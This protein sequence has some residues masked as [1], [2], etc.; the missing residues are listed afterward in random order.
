LAA[1]LREALEGI[2]F[3]FPAPASASAEAKRA[4]LATE[5]DQS[6]GPA[7]EAVGDPV[8]IAVAGPTGVGKSVLANT[9]IGGAYSA[10]SALRPTTGYPQLLAHPD[11][12]AL[13][14]DH[15]VRSVAKAHAVWDAPV[16]WAILDCGDPFAVGNDSLKAQP[17]VPM[18]AWLAV[19]SAL[20]YGDSLV[21][22]LLRSLAGR[23]EPIALVVNRVSE[24][25]GATIEA[26]VKER[27]ANAGLDQIA[28]FTVAEAAG[29]P[30]TLP[31]EHVADL[32]RWLEDQFPIPERLPD[33]PDLRVAVGRLAEQAA[34]LADAQA[35]HEASVDLLRSATEAHLAE[36]AQAAA[37][38]TPGPPDPGLAQAWLDQLGPHGALS[39]IDQE[40]T[41]EQRRRLAA[42][43]APLSR[44]VS[45]AV[46][47]GFRRIMTDARAALASVWQGA[48]VP[49]GTRA[50]LVRSGLDNAE[51]GADLGG[52]AGYGLWTQAVDARLRRSGD[53]AVRRAAEA[54]GRPGLVCLAQAAA[55]GLEGPAGF[56]AG[57]L[58]DEGKRLAE[59][60]LEDLREVRAGAVRLALAVFVDTVRDVER[61][62]SDT[63][64][65]AADRLAF[66][67]KQVD[68]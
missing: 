41:P 25:T 19:T 32:R 38:F 1:I 33:G 47:P 35:V 42:G 26:D 4:A 13:Q 57:W 53:Q 65:W 37:D 58:G 34:E 21:W 36:A 6:A 63:L 16:A 40:I 5:L 15:R 50:L 10:V 52:S 48:E 29:A 62:A 51:L 59:G 23:P 14:G 68:Q 17:D 39:Q 9:L 8:L 55:L 3:P 24:D 56:L 2:E 54:F 7:L 22:D 45:D 60:A 30:E 44:A 11:T 18:S 67:A 66:A 31:A 46:G 20:R 61:T 49:E 43:L 27:L 64:V 12:V 28:L